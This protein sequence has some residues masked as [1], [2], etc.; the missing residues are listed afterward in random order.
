MCYLLIYFEYVSQLW[1]KCVFINK[2]SLSW[3]QVKGRDGLIVVRVATQVGKQNRQRSLS[4]NGIDH[5]R[6][7]L[8]NSW[9]TGERCHLGNRRSGTGGLGGNAAYIHRH[10]S[11]TRQVCN[12]QRWETNDR[13]T[14]D[15]RKYKIKQE[16][17]KSTN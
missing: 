14:G 3:T 2:S 13:K 6:T 8:T 5:R 1:I 11:Q 10:S 7:H 16:V 17:T 12:S 15:K 4:N 9:K